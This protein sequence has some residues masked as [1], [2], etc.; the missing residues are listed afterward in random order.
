MA[1]GPATSWSFSVL[2]DGATPVEESANIEAAQ[3]VTI[4]RGRGSEADDIQP[5]VLSTS[6]WNLDGRYTPDNPLSAL[7]PNV[8]DGCKTRFSVTR[9]GVTSFRHRGRLTVGEPVMDGGNPG[10][11]RVDVQ[12][13]DMLG[14]LSGRV[15]RCDFVERWL[16]TAE[17]KT[18]DLFPV[19]G[20][21]LENIGSGTGTARIIPAQSGVGAYSVVAPDGIDTPS[22]IQ[23]EVS[24]NNSWGPII[25]ADASVPS[26]SVNAIVVPFRTGARAAA[27]GGSKYV[28]MGLNASGSTVWSLRLVDNAG[29]CDLNLHDGSGSF[30]SSVYFGFA[31]V[32]ADAGDDQWFTFVLLNQAGTQFAVLRRAVDDAV[33]STA[34]PA[35][36]ARTTQTL[37]VGGYLGGRRLPG[38]Q[39]ACT[40]MQVGPLV[41]SDESAS[42]AETYLSTQVRTTANAR[43][44]DM[45]LYAD[46]G[47]TTTGSTDKAIWRK[48]IAGRTAFEVLTEIARTTGGL[49]VALK[50][51]DDSLGFYQPDTQRSATVALTVNLAQD[52][53][54]TGGFEWRKGDSPTRVTATYPGGEVVY[55]TGITPRVDSSVD[56]A[57]WD[58]NGARDV[59]SFVA[60]R[61]R[62]LR[63]T[64]LVVDLASA[65]NDLWSSVM[66]LEV[67]ARIRCTIGAS[68]DLP[69]TQ[70]GYTYV[71]VCAVGWTEHYGQDYA[72][73]EIDTVPAD[74]PVAGQW[75][76]GTT[77]L[78]QRWAAADGAM[79]VTGGTCVGSTSTGTVIV[80]TASGPTFTTSAGAYPMDLNWNGEHI[81]VSAPGGS[82]S[83]QTFTVTARGVNGTVA[84]SHSSGEAVNV[85][86]PACWTI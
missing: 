16:N 4:T 6:L 55:D 12:S 44:I 56:T 13:V 77:K 54:L 34:A 27:G 72:F 36:D 43:Y 75:G 30:V 7:Y 22:A 59:A 53:D 33:I 26:G 14:Q 62:R 17:T 1:V 70:Y 60:N 29:Q 50:T 18:V 48:S 47:S 15:M 73:W 82:A 79:T 8:K 46:F 64:R 24:S 63:L 37:V 10:T 80:T 28:A 32:G 5:G 25:Q 45:N 31:A 21:N 51:N 3:G 2:W 71:D 76:D 57:A 61:S 74:D 38:K 19:E 49:A 39:T 52:A 58:A 41:L 42:G 11:S 40:T 69:V 20:L 68:G 67:G 84:R 35:L 66:S 9:G 85:A 81:T 86:L 78:R 65:S 23:L 83:P